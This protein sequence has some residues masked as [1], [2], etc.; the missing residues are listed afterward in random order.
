MKLKDKTVAELMTERHSAKL[1]QKG[2]KIEQD[3]L[4][5][6]VEAIRMSPSSYGMMNQR[7]IVL[8]DGE[9]KES[10]NPIFFGAPNHLTASAQILI[11]TDK[12]DKLKNETMPLTI[13]AKFEGK[14]EELKAKYFESF[15]K[16]WDAKFG[17]PN[18]MNHANFWSQKQAYIALGIALVAAEQFGIDACPQEGYDRIKLEE[19]FRSKNLLAN[20][21]EITLSILLGKIEGEEGIGYFKKVRKDKKD[22]VNYIK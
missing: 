16:I 17:A 8:V 21:E 15:A 1:F 13:N 4:D 9:F 2:F 11:I 3:I 10:L 14:P 5:S 12:A 19:L 22:F 20:D 7:V 18:D 6:I